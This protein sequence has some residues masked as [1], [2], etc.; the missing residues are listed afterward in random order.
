[1]RARVYCP[2]LVISDGYSRS[3]REKIVFRD[4]ENT[5]LERTGGLPARR[6]GLAL[7]L[8]LLLL[9][10]SSKEPNNSFFLYLGELEIV[11]EVNPVGRTH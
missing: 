7:R 8:R 9:F 6:F 4:S 11:A 5:R 3:L 10:F 1:M 2:F